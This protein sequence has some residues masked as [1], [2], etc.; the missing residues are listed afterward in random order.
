M[1]P[2]KTS[3]EAHDQSMQQGYITACVFIT[4][5]Y[6]RCQFHVPESSS[7]GEVFRVLKN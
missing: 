1:A 3:E 4:A 7:G 2:V 5:F 6:F